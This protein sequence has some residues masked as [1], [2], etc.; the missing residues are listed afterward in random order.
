MWLTMVTIL[1]LVLL[2]MSIIYR[3]LWKESVR[4]WNKETK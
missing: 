2:A 4:R 3:V 1:N